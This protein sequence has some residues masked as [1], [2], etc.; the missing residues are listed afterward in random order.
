MSP[1]NPEIRKLSRILKRGTRKT[2]KRQK[3]RGAGPK[4]TED[5]KYRR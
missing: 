4:S 2:R 1:S 3:I 5:K